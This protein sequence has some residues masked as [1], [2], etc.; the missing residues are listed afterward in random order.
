[1]EGFRLGAL[2]RL[3]QKG[4]IEN[5]A[6]KAKSVVFTNDGLRQAEELFRTLFTRAPR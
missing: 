1:M 5:P 4:L 3:Y 6:N 2:D